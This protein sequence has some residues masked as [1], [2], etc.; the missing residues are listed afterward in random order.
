M[1]PADWEGQGL[2]VGVDHG[3]PTARADG[4]DA[5]QRQVQVRRE[6]AERVRRRW[7]RCER[8][9]VVVAAG[10]RHRQQYGIGRHRRPPGV[11]QR[12]ARGL[13]PRRNAGRG[14]DVAQIA[15]QP[16]RQVDRRVCQPD[17][18]RAER[19][20]R[21]WQPVAPGQGADPLII[22]LNKKEEISLATFDMDKI[23]EFRR[24]EQ[25]RMDYRMSF[26]SK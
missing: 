16:V 22:K 25:W 11:G 5:G 4:T 6:G 17:Q 15:D 7:R 3:H 20:A 1:A 2:A 8:Q 9:L 10:E 19:A 23:R 26:K 14:A 21:L 18:P 24:E 12:H 13:D